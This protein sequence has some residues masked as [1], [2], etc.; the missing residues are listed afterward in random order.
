MNDIIKPGQGVLFMK[1]GTHANE[2]LKDIVERKRREIDR[3]GFAFWGYG[4]NTCHPSTMV[5]PFAQQLAESGSSIVLCMEP[6]ESR[7]FAP[8]VRADEYSAD[9]RNWSTIPKGIDAVGSRFALLIETLE[10]AEFDLPLAQTEVAVGPNL[11]RI[12]G[13]YIQGR[14]DKACLVVREEAALVNDPKHARTIR[15]GL[16]AKLRDPYAVF[17]RSKS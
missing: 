17:L 3:E 1:V 16:T 4:G 8:P 10:E 7:H 11:G 6:M 12:G 5:Q 15:I 14:V 2:D 13:Q 9:G